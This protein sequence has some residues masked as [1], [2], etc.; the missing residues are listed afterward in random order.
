M[1]VNERRNAKQTTEAEEPVSRDTW[2]VPPPQSTV[3]VTAG[4]AHDTIPTP[5]PDPNDDVADIEIPTLRGLDVQAA[6]GTL[7]GAGDGSDE[8]IQ[9][10]DGKAGS[11]D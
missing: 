11:E 6:L 1:A 7:D 2:P 10:E 3:I 4:S 9:Q 8:K 5:P